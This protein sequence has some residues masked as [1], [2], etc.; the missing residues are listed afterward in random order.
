MMLQGRGTQP[1]AF[2]LDL[3]QSIVAKHLFVEEIY[4][5][6]N[7]IR[8]PQQHHVGHSFQT[9][10][11]TMAAMAGIEDS[12]IQTMGRWHSSAF[13]CTPKERLA[14]SAALA[15]QGLLHLDCL[16]QLTLLLPS[17]L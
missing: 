16:S 14:T 10:A 7:E 2:F 4:H 3:S 15:T 9:G 5:I 13:L 12:M 17:R 1:G 8:L 11:A 6:L